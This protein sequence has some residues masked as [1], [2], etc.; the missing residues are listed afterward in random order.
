MAS[1]EWNVNGHA[2][3][4]W[5][6][7]W[8]GKAEISV[9]GVPI[10]YRQSPPLGIDFG[11]VRCFDVDGVRCAVRVMPNWYCAFQIDLFVGPD[12]EEMQNSDSAPI[13]QTLVSFLLMGLSGFFML[14]CLLTILFLG[15]F[16]R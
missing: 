10:I 4:V 13:T 9:D 7:F 12:A 1:R 16:R 3:S 14:A 6:R 11:F 5:H 2:I 15:A 8:S